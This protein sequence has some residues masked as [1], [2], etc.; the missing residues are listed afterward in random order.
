MKQIFSNQFKL[1]QKRKRLPPPAREQIGFNPFMVLLCFLVVATLGC[2]R[3][4]DALLNPTPNNKT[5][6]IAAAA[7]NL[8]AGLWPQ[9]TANNIVVAHSLGGLV[10]RQVDRNIAT[11][12]L[13]QRFGG[14]ITVGSSHNGAFLANSFLNGNMELF[15]EDGYHKLTKA[16]I[17]IMNCSDLF[18]AIDF[19]V[20]N[21][22]ADD[23]CDN[24]F[25]AVE[26]SMGEFLNDCV[27]D[28]ATNSQFLNGP[29][30]LKAF[31]KHTGKLLWLW[32][33]ELQ[34][35]EIYRH[36]L[37]SRYQ[38]NNVLVISSGP[39]VYGIDLNTGTTIWSKWETFSGENKFTGIGDLFIYV[40]SDNGDDL[41][42]MGN[43]YTGV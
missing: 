12:I 17:S 10:T 42:K 3:R 20:L 13:D 18:S 36:V 26:Q 22:L 16:A 23:L 7:T 40:A 30:G 43:V 6:G 8:H 29:T 19:I 41:L 21:N 4:D 5:N 34:E 27:T 37:E 31:N 35:K 28:L 33:G 25:E 1:N 9:T 11:G 38:Y 14:Y 24:L 39:R 2:L 15:F 32:E